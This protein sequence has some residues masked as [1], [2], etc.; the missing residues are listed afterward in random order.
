MTSATEVEERLKEW[1]TERKQGAFPAGKEKETRREGAGG[2]V[3][4]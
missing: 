2:I 3:V 1:R 4:F